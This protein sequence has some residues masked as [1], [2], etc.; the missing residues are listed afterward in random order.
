MEKAARQQLAD[1]LK[2]LVTIEITE[3]QSPYVFYA[4]HHVE[5]GI[6]APSFALANLTELQH[7]GDEAPTYSYIYSPHADVMGFLVAENQLTR[8][9][10]I[11]LLVEIMHEAAFFGFQ[12]EE[13]SQAHQQ[14]E[15][16]PT[17]HS[18]GIDDT[19]LP[20]VDVF[21]DAEKLLV[22]QIHDLQA[23]IACSSKHN[24]IAEII[25]G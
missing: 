8:H 20:K 21:S 6:P 19:P 7:Q 25:Q 16:L 17:P 22:K 10:Q 11:E 14:L 4:Y 24:A 13:L 9:Y 1:Y 3:R 12:Q 18:T 2:R 23:R 5:N 15:S